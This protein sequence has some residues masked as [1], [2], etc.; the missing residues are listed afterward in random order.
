M[1]RVYAEVYATTLVDGG[2][3]G[4]NTVASRH[5][6]VAG[7]RKGEALAQYYR[8]LDAAE[9]AF[10]ASGKFPGYRP[11]R[12]IVRVDNGLAIVCQ[13]RGRKGW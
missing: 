11:M 1:K 6:I 13:S 7:R 2:F 8:A 5:G 10:R 9:A 3:A 12:A 4:Y